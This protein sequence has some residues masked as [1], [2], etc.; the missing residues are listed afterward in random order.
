MN[1][2]ALENIY[3]RTS[4]KNYKSDKVDEKL[5]DEVIKAGVS[6]ATGKNAQSPII[7]KI[8][9]KQVRDELSALNAS[10][11][12]RD[13][14]DPF[15]N[16]PVVLVVLAKKDVFTHVYDGSIVMA[17]MMLA[18]HALGLGSC[19]IHRAKEEFETEYGK[20]LL[21]DLGINEEY[22]GIG[23]LVLGYE[24]VK[25]NPKPRKENWVYEIK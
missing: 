2:Q 12:G 22:E 20:K 7:L 23:N 11:M 9:N 25:S 15:Y 19:W 3:T 10:I 24:E 13:G 5:I 21:K 18:A 14:I 4:C 1:K 17:N 16:A 8:T 6:S